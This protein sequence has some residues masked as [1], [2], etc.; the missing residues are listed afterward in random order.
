MTS[1]VDLKKGDKIILTQS[2]NSARNYEGQVLTITQRNKGYYQTKADNGSTLTVYFGDGYAP[3]TFTLATRE[4]QAEYMG[5]RIVAVKKELV[6]LEKE[7]EH[8]TKYASEEEFVATKLQAILKSDS[9]EAIT[10]V[11]KELKQSN[12]I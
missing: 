10:E 5:K 12:L 11:L 2:H 1:P 4:A 3:D 7:L 9:V 6:E 8:L